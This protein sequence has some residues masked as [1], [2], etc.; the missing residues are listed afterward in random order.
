[1]EGRIGSIDGRDAATRDG[2]Q[3]EDEE[4]SEDCKVVYVV[5]DGGWGWMVLLGSIVVNIL[6]PGTV[7]SFGVLFV[8]FLEVFNASPSAAAWI[9]ALSYWLYSSM[10]ETTLF[11]VHC[12]FLIYLTQTLFRRSI[13]KRTSHTV[14]TSL[15]HYCRW[16]AR[17]TRIDVE[18]L[19]YFHSLLICQV[20][21]IDCYLA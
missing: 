19:C 17:C 5:P 14:L 11:S 7:K 6:I 13:C 15:R 8:E 20:C 9:P 21:R 1:V 4:N 12:L 16:I 10:G 18:L 3:C 2:R